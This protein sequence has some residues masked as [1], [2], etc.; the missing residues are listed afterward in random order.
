MN[1]TQHFLMSQARRYGQ[2]LDSWASQVISASTAVDAFRIATRPPAA[3]GILAPLRAMVQNDKTRATHRI[4]ADLDRRLTKMA[5][6][7]LAKNVEILR[8]C[9]QGRFPRLYN[10]IIAL[11]RA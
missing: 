8:K 10:K 3:G 9:T 6:E 5:P 1:P 11:T 4:E 2:Q 7:D